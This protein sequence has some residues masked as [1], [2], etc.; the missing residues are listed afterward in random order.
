MPYSKVKIPNG[1]TVLQLSEYHWQINGVILINHYPLS[2]R[3]TAYIQNTTEGISN[4]GVKQVLKWANN[5]SK[6]PRN[7]L[8][9]KVKRKNNYRSE[10][11]QL[12]SSGVCD[13][14]WCKKPLMDD[15]TLEHII[16]LSKGGLDCW[17][18][19]TLA[20]LKCNEKHGDKIEASI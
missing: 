20:H 3:R 12:I 15:Y 6:I 1:V 7:K 19:W 8:P 16:P 17:S 18:N 10:K 4:V 5:P 11:R 2:K 9:T 13:C 14:F